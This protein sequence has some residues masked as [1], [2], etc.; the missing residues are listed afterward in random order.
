MRLPG[1]QPGE[2]PPLSPPATLWMMI[3][4]VATFLSQFAW[5]QATNF[6]GHDEWLIVSLNAKHVVGFPYAN[7][8]LVLLG[9]LPVAL[10]W[11]HDLKA[12]LFFH[13]LYLS[14]S[15]VLVFLLF[16]R[17]APR[18]SLLAFLTAVFSLVWVPLDFMRLDTVL[19]TG[20]A[21]FTFVTFLA[22]FLLVESW[23]RGSVV[24]LVAGAL[25][26]FVTTRGGEATVPL[27]ALAP[28]LLVPLRGGRRL[29]AWVLVWES[30]VV[31]GVALILAP[32]ASPG[33]GSYQLSALG[34]DPYPLHVT[35][36]LLEQ[37]RFHL[38][39]L[40]TSPPREI[41]P[42][43]VV[44][45]VG[46]FGLAYA[47]ATR[48]GTVAE[49][50]AADTRFLPGAMLLGL[51]W[52]GL[53]YSVYTLSR[54]INTPARTQILSSPGIG[55]F[56]A[57][58]LCLVGRAF[59]PPW[60]RL[61]IGLLAGWVVAV[62]T[63]RTLAM[64]REWD[65]ASAWP[66]QNGALVNLTRAAP[67]LKPN[68]FVLLIDEAGAWPATFTFRHAVEYLYRGRAIGSVWGAQEFLYPTTFAG[69]GVHS[70]PWEVIRK[71]WG[72][73]ASHHG[74]EEVMVVALRAWG[75]LDILDRWPGGLPPLPPGAVYR[76][77]ERI[78]AGGSLPEERG[79]LVGGR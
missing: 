26:A 25:L 29:W 13:T 5:V 66:A 67:D 40:F 79:I 19:M 4:T 38:L 3:G 51:V 11:P 39:P 33:Q 43:G 44:A 58:G 30:L 34:L 69:D 62:G 10:F 48:N 75:E 28:A 41:A 27:V 74:Y 46:V 24:L 32:L 1:G 59:A 23:Q 73:A 70:D 49:E 17:L 9:S 54:A 60:R 71:P 45:A 37:F 12:Y 68:T 76:P 22:V 16:R 2:A 47:L 6:G 50:V 36:R 64:Q 77:R 31:A 42:I 15:G 78:V 52:A 18:S 65:M 72:S 21:G 57:G 56:L 20:Y 63:G 35:G 53:G 7:R 8:P 61:I 55:L 14:L